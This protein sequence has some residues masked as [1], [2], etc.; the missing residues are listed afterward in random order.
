[1]SGHSAFQRGFCFSKQ[2]QLRNKV[3][4]E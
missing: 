2:T 3:S 4:R 1:M